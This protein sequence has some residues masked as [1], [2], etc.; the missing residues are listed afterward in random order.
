[1]TRLAVRMGYP[2][3]YP[4]HVEGECRGCLWEPECRYARWVMDGRGGAP[5][6][7]G[8]DRDGIGEAEVV[9]EAHE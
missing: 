9:R 3:C 5:T 6:D 1:M 2:L 4:G 7:G 8:D